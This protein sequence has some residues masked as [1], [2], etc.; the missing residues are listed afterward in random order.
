MELFALEEKNPISDNSMRKAIYCGAICWA[1][2]LIKKIHFSVSGRKWCQDNKGCQARHWD[3]MIIVKVKN[4]YTVEQHKWG[5]SN[6]LLILFLRENWE[7]VARTVGKS[8]ER[9]ED[10]QNSSMICDPL[11]P[12]FMKKNLECSCDMESGDR[13][14]EYHKEWLFGWM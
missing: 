7:G 3:V 9:D 12:T 4:C 14:L 13:W 10:K 11:I 2:R 6:H 8:R 5:R 1:L